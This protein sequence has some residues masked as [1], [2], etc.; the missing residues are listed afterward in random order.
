MVA[1]FD[2]A[3]ASMGVSWEL[4]AIASAVIGGASLLGGS[5]SI[6]GVIIG[7]SIIGVIQNGLVLMK[8]SSYWQTLIIGCIII[9]AAVQGRVYSHENS[10]GRDAEYRKTFRRDYRP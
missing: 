6:L 7:A 2:S 8:V 1:R 3:Q 5:G 4:D 10:P 9:L